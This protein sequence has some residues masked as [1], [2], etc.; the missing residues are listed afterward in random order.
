MVGERVSGPARLFVS[1]K[2]SFLVSCPIL[3]PLLTL[4][5]Q[6]EPKDTIA[7]V[8]SSVLFDC[9]VGGEPQPTVSWKKRNCVPVDEY[10]KCSDNMPIGRA[11]ITD[12]SRGLRI[13]R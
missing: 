5:P 11:Y 6:V 7:E 3:I 9:R 2:P 13:D 1:E 8:N 4:T 10:S 12:D